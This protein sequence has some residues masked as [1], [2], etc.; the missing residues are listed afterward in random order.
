METYRHH[1]SGFYAVR[2]DAAQTEPGRMLPG[3]YRF[4]QQGYV[5]AW[6]DSLLPV[7]DDIHAAREHGDLADDAFVSENLQ[8][9]LS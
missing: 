9:W 4:N 2:A 3:I 5:V 7:L 1:I 6:L 8:R